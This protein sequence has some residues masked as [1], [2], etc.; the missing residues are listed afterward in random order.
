MTRPEGQESNEVEAWLVKKIREKGLIHLSTDEVSMAYKSKSFSEEWRNCTGSAMPENLRSQMAERLNHCGRAPSPSPSLVERNAAG[1]AFLRAVASGEAETVNRWLESKDR[2]QLMGAVDDHQRGCLHLAAKAGHLEVLRL[3]HDHGA[4]LEARDRLKRTALH[5]ACEYGRRQAAEV[6]LGYDCQAGSEDASKRTALHL[7]AVCEDP[8]IARLLALRQPGLVARPDQHSRT[9][10]FYSVLNTHPQAMAEITRQFLELQ[11]E[12]NISDAY[13][14]TPLHYAAEEGKKAAVTLLLRQRADPSAED[15]VNGRSPIMLAAKHEAVRRELQKAVEVNA[16]AQAGTGRS[17]VLPAVTGPG[18]GRASPGVANA[19]AGPPASIPQ[20]LRPPA[21][22][23]TPFQ[24]L[25]DRFVK[26]MERV[27]EGGIEQ[28]EHIKRPHLF[29]GSWMIDISSHHQL[30][31]QALKHVPSSEVCIRVF[32]LLRPPSTFPV[33]QGDEQQIMAI[34]DGQQGASTRSSWGGVDPYAAAAKSGE[35]VDD[36]SQARRVELLRTIHDQK[37]DLDAKEL[38]V[39]EL[40][41]KVEGLQADVRERGEPGELQALRDGAARAKRQQATQAEELETV[42]GRLSIL[43]G[44]NRV[45]QEQ[46]AG[47]KQRSAELLA[48]Q[49]AVRSQLQAM[50]ARRGEDQAWKEMLEQSKRQ[51]ETVQRRLE[52]QL[53]EVQTGK[54]DSEDSETRLR[55][56]VRQLQAELDQS[57]A[58]A[59]G[60]KQADQLRAEASSHKAEVSRLSRNIEQVQSQAARDTQTCRAEVLEQMQL[61]EA[62]ERESRQLRADVAQLPILEK[63]RAKLEKDLRSQDEYWRKMF[64]EYHLIGQAFFGGPPAANASAAQCVPVQVQVPMK[65]PSLGLPAVKPEQLPTQSD[66]PA[67]LP[68]EGLL[69]GVMAVLGSGSAD[70]DAPVTKKLQFEGSVSEAPPLP[71]PPSIDPA[72]DKTPM[73]LSGIF[74]K[75][76]GGARLVGDVLAPPSAP[77]GAPPGPPLPPLGATS[78]P[79]PSAPPASAQPPPGAPPPGKV[80]LPPGVVPPSV[81]PPSPLPP[82]VAPP[83]TAAPPP[84]PPPPFAFVK[85]LG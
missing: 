83:S 76:K 78:V 18:H 79:P 6:L 85:D 23:G 24:V 69:E 9:P 15:T 57:T 64:R 13:G 27:Q 35:D 26:I 32:N 77:A 21:A 7:A 10:L 45:I 49:C 5:L 53:A 75:L 38:I 12:V 25:Q 60:E 34:Y 59:V 56:Q 63:E 42:E 30:L 33:S 84:L 67:A 58:N 68:D 22:L 14:M 17:M 44:Q 19:W 61:R 66:R 20:S 3:L 1:P 80:A 54:L 40:R 36:L 81:K 50:M 52:D 74:G 55:A 4:D 29:T 48:D 37:K 65:V 72:L 16:S 11:A 31:G 28:M 82:G 8:Q 62:S 47:E 43:Q 73:S 71:P 70:D 2:R 46:L 51:A 41:R 39:E